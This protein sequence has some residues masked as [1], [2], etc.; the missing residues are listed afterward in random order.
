[1]SINI[2]ADLSQQSVLR[3]QRCPQ[4]NAQDAECKWVRRIAPSP[5]YAAVSKH[6]ARTP[7]WC[8]C[9]IYTSDPNRFI[10]DP[11]SQMPGLNT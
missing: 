8:I 10:K 6:S 7:Y 5:G 3:F 2:G 4:S 11:I 9:K 1:M